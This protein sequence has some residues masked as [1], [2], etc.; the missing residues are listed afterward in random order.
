MAVLSTTLVFSC[1]TPP[2]T[3]ISTIMTAH[4]HPNQSESRHARVFSALFS[5][6][7]QPFN[8]FREFDTSGTGTQVGQPKRQHPESPNCTMKITNLL[9]DEDSSTHQQMDTSAVIDIGVAFGQC[10]RS[11][12]VNMFLA[13]SFSDALASK[14]ADS[15][16]MDHTGG[17]K[18]EL[19]Y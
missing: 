2:Y 7:S 1:G 6:Q 5:F 16:L 12:H 8:D 13:L 18:G 3:S 9:E 11:G 17:I 14:L 19:H 15:R 4:S 10:K